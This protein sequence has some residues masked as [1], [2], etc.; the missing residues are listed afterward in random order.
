MSTT[1][2][3]CTGAPPLPGDS[4]AK[5][6]ALLIRRAGVCGHEGH[7]AS[8]PL[9]ATHHSE[10]LLF[11]SAGIWEVLIESVVGLIEEA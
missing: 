3:S 8:P 6:P 9:L 5:L 1:C 10:A 2:C 7:C 11:R 4:L